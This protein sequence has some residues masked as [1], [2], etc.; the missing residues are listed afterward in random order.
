MLCFSANLSLLF[1]EIPMLER[2]KAANECGFRGVEIQFPYDLPAEL[3]YEQLDKNDLE[4]IL[5]NVPAGDLMN[6]GEGLAAVPSKRDKFI[7]AVKIA[8]KYA[9]ILRPKCINVLPG[10]CFENDNLDQYLETFKSNLIYTA[11]V[12]Q[13]LQI[14]VVFEAANL[15][16]MPGFIICKNDQLVKLVEE[17]EH[18][19]VF[20]QYDIY[21]M[22]TMNEDYYNFIQKYSNIIGHIQFADSPG[23]HQPGTGEIDFVNLFKSIEDSE[24]KGWIGAEYRPSV[25]TRERLDWFDDFSSNNQK[26]KN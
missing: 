14:K 9:E 3:I 22:H 11:D 10:C 2:F 17:L 6:G 24:Y 25:P 20:V 15:I 19:N 18:R 5:I 12:F 26:G 8:V 1:T 23:R 7:E 16:D 13:G 4:L 21:H